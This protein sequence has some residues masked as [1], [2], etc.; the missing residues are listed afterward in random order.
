MGDIPTANEARTGAVT[1]FAGLVEQAA[2][3]RY[4]PRTGLSPD[5]LRQ[6]GYVGLLTALDRYDPC[7]GA[8]LKTYVERC[9]HTALID[10]IRRYTRCRLSRRPA[11][12][13]VEDWEPFAAK[14]QSTLAA[15]ESR[16]EQQK[17]L[18]FAG[19]LA[20]IVQEM[21]NTGDLL[22]ET[23]RRF[24]KTRGQIAHLRRVLKRRLKPCCS[25]YSPTR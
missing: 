5:D 21:L 16:D 13:Q 25:G 11:F 4:R 12:H 1:A 10:A 18:R 8:S 2:A 7:R 22:E 17:L 6:I 15:L 19:P 9:V 3:Y 20:P 14:A 24:S 23:A